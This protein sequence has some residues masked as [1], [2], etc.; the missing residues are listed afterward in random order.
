MDI[1][2][3]GHALSSL[4]TS[5]LPSPFNFND[6]TLRE[7]YFLAN[8]EFDPDL[9]FQKLMAF[10]TLFLASAP[11]IIPF[12]TG[13]TTACYNSATEVVLMNGLRRFKFGVF[14]SEVIPMEPTNGDFISGY[15][16]SLII[17][18]IFGCLGI[19]FL[20]MNR[21]RPHDKR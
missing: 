1:M 16:Q 20:I 9:R 3:L 15:T 6:T 13:H 19:I 2:D 21:I 10:Q 8:S 11:S 17:G 12:G 18:T 4:F 14:Y 7:A 5:L